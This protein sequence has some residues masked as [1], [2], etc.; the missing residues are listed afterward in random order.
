MRP[1]WNLE[2]HDG[3]LDDVDALAQLVL[4]DDEGRGQADDVA[5]GGLRQQAVVTETQTH[6]PGVVVWGKRENLDSQPKQ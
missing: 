6:L 3:A 2:G 4:L 5:V 1:C